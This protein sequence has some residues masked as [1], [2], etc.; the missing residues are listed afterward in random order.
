MHVTH[1]LPVPLPMLHGEHI[2]LVVAVDRMQFLDKFWNGPVRWLN[3][4]IPSEWHWTM[5]PQCRPRVRCEQSMNR[6]A[7]TLP[8]IWTE[9]SVCGMDLRA[10]KD[11]MPL[12]ILS[13]SSDYH[14]FLP[15]GVFAL[16]CHFWCEDLVSIRNGEKWLHKTCKVIFSNWI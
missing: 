3:E 15:F 1:V 6:N 12:Y 7:E 8:Q 14:R 9:R 2:R 16:F 13:K 4:V 11:H 5:D 10:N